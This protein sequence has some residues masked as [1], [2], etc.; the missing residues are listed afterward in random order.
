LFEP[1]PGY[2]DLIADAELA[3]PPGEPTAL[4]V[5]GVGTVLAHRT[6][7]A[8]IATLAMAANPA[9]KLPEQQE[10]LAR[11]V[12]DHLADGEYE[13]LADAMISD[14]LP[15]DTFFL[16]GRQIATRGTPRPY[17][18]VI[19][20]AVQTGYHWREIRRRIHA[21]GIVD[22]MQLPSMHAV[23]DVTEHAV[24]ESMSGEDS[25]VKRARF[26]DSLYAPEPGQT[27]LNGSEYAPPP[28][29]SPDEVEATFDAFTAAMR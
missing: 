13:R 4:D 7:P 27:A 28:G 6:R 16:V 26:Y 29:F 23:L 2:V 20:L 12:A 22:P 15:A 1:P 10:Y 18:A 17:T 3:P 11:F 9:L 19:T 14:D 5:P 24:L 21:A 8:S 25:A